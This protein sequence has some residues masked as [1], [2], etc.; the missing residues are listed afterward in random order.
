MAASLTMFVA[1]AVAQAADKSCKNSTLNG[2]YA[3]HASGFNV[4]AGVAQPKAIVEMID[5]NGD[6]T[7]G[8][9]GATISINGIISRSPPSANGGTYVVN[10]DCSGS[11]AFPTGPTWDLFIGR[12]A[13]QLYM[14]QTGPGTPV[15]Q[16]TADWVSD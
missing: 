8:G 14:I 16:G 12:K 10:P 3:L 1:S 11:L 9:G 5:F 4:V 7:M 2:L 6:G 15:F 13:S